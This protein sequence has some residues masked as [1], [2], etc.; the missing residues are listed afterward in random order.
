MDIWV[1]ISSVITITLT[2]ATPLIFGALGATFSERSGVANIGIEGMMIFGA[3]FAAV[4]SFFVG[5][6]VTDM[7]TKGGMSAET[8]A[9]WGNTV[10]PILGLMAAMVAGGLLAALLAALSIQFKANQ[11][12]VGVAINILAAS[13]ASYGLIAIWG[14]PGQTPSVASFTPLLS[15]GP[16][17]DVPVLNNLNA[18]D[19]LAL[20]LIPIVWFVLYKTPGG[21]RIRA[22]GEHP[23]AADTLGVS[24]SKVR[25]WSVVMSGVLAGMGGA[26]I[27]I[28]IATAFRDG[29]VS[30]KG[31][32]AIAAMIFGRWHPVGAAM[33]CLFFGLADGFRTIAPQLGINIP[34][35]FLFMLP[36]V[37][38]ILAV[39]GVIGRSTA[40]A[41]DG[42]PYE[43]K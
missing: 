10:A 5:P 9:N 15:N 34:S 32:I 7:F 17:K 8:A 30:G 40:P 22:V 31:F 23:R 11:I 6:A 35:E 41:A 3:F 28:G 13:F 26:A 14:V 33:A 36:Y 20:I 29:M 27:S 37:L 21:L 25:Y 2:S 42:V 1:L 18:L 43:K 24:V 38:T 4:V 12:V 19:I 39:S 16:L